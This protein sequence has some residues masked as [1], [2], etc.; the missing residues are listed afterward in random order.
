MEIKITEVLDGQRAVVSTRGLRR[1]ILKKTKQVL[2][3]LLPPGD[4]E[5]F[6]ECWNS[7]GEPYAK[8]VD[9]SFSKAAS[10]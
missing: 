4:A 8:V 5:G 3:E 10:T 1:V 7:G 6:A 2:A 9:Y